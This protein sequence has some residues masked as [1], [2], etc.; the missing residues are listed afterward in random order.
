MTYR[1]LVFGSRLSDFDLDLR[2]LYRNQ[3]LQNMEDAKAELEYQL[4]S[5][6]DEA[7]VEEILN[8]LKKARSS[9]Q[10][11]FNFIPKD[12]IEAALQSVVARN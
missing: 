12:D 7:D 10:E 11:W 3:V 4:K 5:I 8:Y 9:C 1:S 2:D 6:D